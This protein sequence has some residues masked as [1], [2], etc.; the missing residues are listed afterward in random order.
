MVP[1]PHKPGQPAGEGGLGGTARGSCSWLDPDPLYQDF[2]LSVGTQPGLP[3]PA[4]S[5]RA[6]IQPGASVKVTLPVSRLT[7][8]LSSVKGSL[9]LWRPC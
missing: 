2:A 6:G 3:L 9:Y 5:H 8:L 4:H 7:L 1:L